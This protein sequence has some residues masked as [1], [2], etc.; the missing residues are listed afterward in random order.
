[1][2]IKGV[3]RNLIPFPSAVKSASE[4]RNTHSKTNADN[5]REGNGQAAGEEQKRRKLSP[6]EITDAVKYL[7][8]LPGVKENSLRVR[9]EQV[10]GVTVV[11]VE[12]RNGKLVRRI[13]ESE[14]ALLTA[15]REKKSGHLLNKAL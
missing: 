9:M 7:E 1:M 6:E 10:D 14:L 15:N 5:D 2:D 8:D 13:P 3:V 4:A 12:D 11:Y